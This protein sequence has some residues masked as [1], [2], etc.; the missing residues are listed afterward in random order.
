MRPRKEGYIKVP[1]FEWDVPKERRHWSKI[2]QRNRSDFGQARW[3]ALMKCWR[4]IFQ[5]YLKITPRQ[6]LF[7]SR[8]VLFPIW[9]I[10]SENAFHLINTATTTFT[11]TPTSEIRLRSLQLDSS[12]LKLSR[13][14]FG[15]TL[16]KAVLLAIWGSNVCIFESIFYRN[17]IVW[18]K[19][20][21]SASIQRIHRACEP[22]R[23]TCPD[24]SVKIAALATNFD[25]N[26]LFP[27]AN[28][29]R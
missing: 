25:G 7:R 12:V 22:S 28:S 18:F 13:K 17:W 21:I 15:R 10:W 1:Q 4:A 29:S 16:E 5:R 8:R 19:W 23:T 3:N 9:L 6:S 20:S 11:Y 27:K 14:R 26:H 2:A 24:I